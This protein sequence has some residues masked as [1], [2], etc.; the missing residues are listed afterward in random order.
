M[1]KSA[2]AALLHKYSAFRAEIFIPPTLGGRVG[3]FRGFGGELVS[4]A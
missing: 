3:G 1:R 2:E 4:S